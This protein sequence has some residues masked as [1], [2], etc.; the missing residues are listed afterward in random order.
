MLS[1][2]SAAVLAKAHTLLQ[3]QLSPFRIS[4]GETERHC[5]T[6]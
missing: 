5:F 3:T 1:V 6:E 4:P 2:T